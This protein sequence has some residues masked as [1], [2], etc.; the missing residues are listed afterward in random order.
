MSSDDGGED[1]RA[2]ALE[3]LMVT[4]AHLEVL[5]KSTKNPIYVWEAISVQNFLWKYPQ[6]FGGEHFNLITPRWVGDYLVSTAGHLTLLNSGHVVT[7]HKKKGAQPSSI[8]P[9]NPRLSIDAVDRKKLNDK[10][11]AV[12][13]LA[14]DGGNAFKKYQSTRQDLAISS[15]VRELRSSGLTRQQAI[16]Q[17]MTES[18]EI[19]FSVLE[20]RL[21]RGDKLAKLVNIA[22]RTPVTNK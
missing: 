11:S 21:T 14:V 2:K 10:V 19:D 5:Y 13:G 16:T 17:Y 3:R 12:L 20:K 8:D 9:N 1:P 7:D 22:R 18:K 6:R 4:L 15:R